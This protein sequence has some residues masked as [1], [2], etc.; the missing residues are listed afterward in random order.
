MS[1]ITC[2]GEASGE[3]RSRHCNLRLG[4]RCEVMPLLPNKVKANCQMGS[5]DV[6]V[7]MSRRKAA[8]E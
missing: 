4:Y 6:D 7:E 3:V 5:V 1:N 2:F 8:L